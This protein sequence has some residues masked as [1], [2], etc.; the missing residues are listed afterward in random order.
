MNLDLSGLD[1]KWRTTSE[2]NP[3]CAVCGKKIGDDEHADRCD[4]P[5]VCPDT[6]SHE[7]ALRIWKGEGQDTKEMAFHLKCAEPRMQPRDG[8]ETRTDT[9]MCQRCVRPWPL[10]RAAEGCPICTSP[11]KPGDTVQITECVND[12]HDRHGSHRGVLE[13]L[14]E[15]SLIGVGDGTLDA[16]TLV[17][18]VTVPDCTFLDRRVYGLKVEKAE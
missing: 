4:E 18:A 16:F 13:T 2:H 6:A 17:Y 12:D 15:A 5:D 14:D 8:E 3:P 10:D 9:V 1:D 7:I 11:V